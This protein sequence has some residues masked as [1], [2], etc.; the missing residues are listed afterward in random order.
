[1]Q[2]SQTHADTEI[3]HATHLIEGTD[4]AAWDAITTDIDVVSRWIPVTYRA[5][6]LITTSYPKG[7]R[8]QLSIFRTVIATSYYYVRIRAYV[9]SKADRTRILIIGRSSTRR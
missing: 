2:F 3:T 9:T 7:F 4:N 5:T 1:M 8:R 6:Y